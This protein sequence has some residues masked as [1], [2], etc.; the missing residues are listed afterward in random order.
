MNS[1][2]LYCKLCFSSNVYLA[3]FLGLSP[4]LMLEDQAQR[5]PTRDNT[6]SVRNEFSHAILALD[7]KQPGGQAS[8]EGSYRNEVAHVQRDNAPYVKP[9][10]LNQDQPQSLA[11]STV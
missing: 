7:K 4:V 6:H 5:R 10:Y 2:N 1:T 11:A 8:L 9:V 3:W